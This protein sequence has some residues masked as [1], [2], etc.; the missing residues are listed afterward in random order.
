[1]K[2]LK[3]PVCAFSN[4]DSETRPAHNYLPHKFVA[5]TVVYTGTHD[6]D[7]TLGWWQSLT[8]ETEKKSILTYLDPGPDGIVWA[9]ILAA[10]TSVADICLIPVQDI[11]QLPTEA[12]MNMPSRANGNWGWR[13]P[14]HVLTPALASRLAAIADVSD[15][16]FVPKTEPVEQAA[17]THHH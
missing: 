17:A 12:R 16:D 2:I 15:R 10:S 7:T 1:M 13:C 6:N 11:L 3:C 8:N 14:E 9:M 4:L 5:N